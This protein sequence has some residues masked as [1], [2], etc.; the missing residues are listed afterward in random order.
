[1]KN[2]PEITK[3][4]QKQ[5]DESNNYFQAKAD[6]GTLSQEDLMEWGAVGPWYDPLNEC[7]NWN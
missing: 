5:I 3:E 7:W 2:K 1:M 6:A 4:E